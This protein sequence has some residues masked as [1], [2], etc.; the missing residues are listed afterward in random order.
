MHLTKRHVAVVATLASV[1]VLNAASVWA[2]GDQNTYQPVTSFDPQRNSFADLKQAIAE[3]GQTQRRIMLEV[4]SQSCLE[5]KNLDQLFASNQT[6]KDLRDRN[7]VWVKINSSRDNENKQFLTQY[8]AISDCPHFFVLTADGHVVH[9]QDTKP[10]EEAKGYSPDRM[11]EFLNRWGPP[12]EID[13]P[14]Q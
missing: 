5:C 13:S 4:G 9:S 10:L 8:P 6:L 3:A 11:K 12:R 1:L 14:L 7:Y 2:Q